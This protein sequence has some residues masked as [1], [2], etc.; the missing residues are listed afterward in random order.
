MKLGKLGFKAW[1]MSAALLCAVAALPLALATPVVYGFESFND[2]DMVSSLVGG[3]TFS[4][5]T[6][7]QAGA[8]LDE[9]EFAPRSGINV[10][11]DNGGPITIDFASPV[12][13]VGGYFNYVA[14]L[15]FSAY[16]SA[17]GLLGTDVAAFANNTALS[18]DASSSTNKLFS[19]SSAGG[20]IARVVS[21]GGN[22]LG[23]SF[24][25]PILPRNRSHPLSDS[26]SNSHQGQY[27]SI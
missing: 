22:P 20:L 23:G 27:E 9:F 13:S 12:F 2:L 14:G 19:F 3:L 21:T 4:N 16:D 15:S 1:A 8:S 11:F 10:V 5:T 18:G 17:T 7:L 24:T 25:L 6:V 26:P